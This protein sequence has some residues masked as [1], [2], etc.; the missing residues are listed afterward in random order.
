MSAFLAGFHSTPPSE[1][2]LEVRSLLKTYRAPDGRR[3]RVVDIP[4]FS[5]GRGEHVALHGASGSGKTTFLNLLGGILLPDEGK[6]HVAGHDLGALRPSKRD[7]VRAQCVGYVFQTFNLLQGYTALE[8]V[9][10]GMLFGRGADD[11]FARELLTRV[12]LGQR[13]LH[14]PRELSV[15]QQQRVAVARA[16]AARPQLVLADEPTGNL[17][18]RRAREAMALMRQLCRDQGAALLVVSHS[19]DILEQFESVR[20]FSDLNRA[21]R[22]AAA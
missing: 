4:T 7:Q 16:L 21:A 5:L 6:V 1:G 19:R 9:L 13:L 3:T 15:G 22:E 14:R 2:V 17:D 18:S 8:N 11:V 12:G 10:M 20:D